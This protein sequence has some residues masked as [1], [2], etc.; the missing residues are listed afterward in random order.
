VY[1][2][3]LSVNFWRFSRVKS[4]KFGFLAFLANFTP[5]SLP[6]GSEKNF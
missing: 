2:K 1:L 6:M 5:L 3:I 4:E